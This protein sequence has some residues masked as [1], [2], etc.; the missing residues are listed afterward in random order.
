[1][2]ILCT[3][4]HA[5]NFFK[6]CW[7][8]WALCLNICTVNSVSTVY[9]W[10]LLFFFSWCPCTQYQHL[11]GKQTTKTSELFL[12]SSTVWIS[13]NSFKLVTTLKNTYGWQCCLLSF[14]ILI[15]CFWIQPHTLKAGLCFILSYMES[16]P[17]GF[18]R[19]GSSG[20]SLEPQGCLPV[21]YIRKEEST[22]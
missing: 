21:L 6:C 22:N 20:I 16:S 1:M 10:F 14:I 13:L 8:A 19:E 11:E 15:G 3:H 18:W 12:F 2:H 7:S 4:T 9:K 17:V 5:W